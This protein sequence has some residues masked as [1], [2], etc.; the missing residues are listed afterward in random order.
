MC[1][2]FPSWYLNKIEFFMSH[3]SSVSI[4]LRWRQVE[5]HHYLPL[6]DDEQFQVPIDWSAMQI[7]FFDADPFQSIY[8]NCTLYTVS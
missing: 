8:V 2:P 5:D 1:I 7:F 4:S 3:A 6:D